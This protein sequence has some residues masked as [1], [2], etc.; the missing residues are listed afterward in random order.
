VWTQK[1]WP[2]FDKVKQPPPG[3]V[4]SP[5][6]HIGWGAEGLETRGWGLGI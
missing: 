2:L 4:V 5:L 6:F 3:E 1:L